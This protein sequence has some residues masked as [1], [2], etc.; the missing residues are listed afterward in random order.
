[1]TTPADSA[2]LPEQQRRRRSKG[3]VH[4]VTGL[5]SDYEDRKEAGALIRIFIAVVLT[6]AI[7]YGVFRFVERKINGPVPPPDPSVLR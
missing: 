2:A 5:S 7:A 4:P 3:G 1:M 6:A